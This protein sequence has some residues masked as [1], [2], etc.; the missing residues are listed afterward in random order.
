M[1]F[2]FLYIVPSVNASNES[3]SSITSDINYLS[4]D[5]ACHGF[6]TSDY[7]QQCSM[8]KV[9]SCVMNENCYDYCSAL[10][11]YK[12]DEEDPFFAMNIPQNLT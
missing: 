6:L 3:P 5:K 9:E 2:L 4:E 8:Q 1:E 10:D 11:C 7:L 12:G